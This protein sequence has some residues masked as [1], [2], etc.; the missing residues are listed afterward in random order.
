SN[1]EIQIY[2]KDP[3]VALLLDQQDWFGRVKA[4][5]GDFLYV[6]DA[7]VGANKSNYYISRK[8]QYSINVDRNSQ[9]NSVAKITWQHDGK[10]GTW[11]GGNYRNYVRLYT[12]LGCK[13]IGAK[14]FDSEELD[15]YV[16]GDKQ[17]FG[18]FVTIPY[19][20]QKVVEVA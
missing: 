16:E 20:N 3:A 10:S 8:T 6:V 14:N 15:V 12:P 2:S 17:V 13:L 5:D 18:G 4:A 19:N 7:N 11:P 9:L 1:Q